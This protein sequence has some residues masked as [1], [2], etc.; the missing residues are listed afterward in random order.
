MVSI[1]FLKSMPRQH[2]YERRKRQWCQGLTVICKR[3]CQLIG[4]IKD[5]GLSRVQTHAKALPHAQDSHSVLQVKSVTETQTR[6]MGEKKSKTE[7]TASVQ[8]N[9]SKTH[10]RLK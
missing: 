7:M 2:N 1:H 4:V 10:K 3:R 6:V 8:G 9:K 5:G